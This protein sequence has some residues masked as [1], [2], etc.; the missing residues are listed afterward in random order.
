MFYEF[1]CLILEGLLIYFKAPHTALLITQFTNEPPYAP[2]V[3]GDHVIVQPAV[4]ASELHFLTCCYLLHTQNK[5][6]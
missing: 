1:L 3:G 2:R 6:F 5:H 4:K